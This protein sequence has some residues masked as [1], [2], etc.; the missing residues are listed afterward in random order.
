MV[1]KDK[2]AGGKITHSGIFSFKEAYNF[3]YSWLTDY[4]FRVV[5]K[6]YSEKVKGEGKDIDV[7]W[8]ASRTLTDYFKFELK[9]EWRV[10]GMVTLKDPK[11]MN[12]GKVS[13]KINGTLVRDPKNKWD[14]S[15]LSKFLRGIYDKFVIFSKIEEYRGRLSEEIDEALAQI[16]SFLSLEARREA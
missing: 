8:H 3:L 14:A 9:V 7:E 10:E 13:V 12:S 2:V 5:E 11:G 1:E 15:A 16:K 4:D 6:K